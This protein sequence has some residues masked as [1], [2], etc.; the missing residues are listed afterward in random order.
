M[1]KSNIIKAFVVV[2]IITV[3]NLCVTN[4]TTASQNYEG[5]KYCQACHNV[6]SADISIKDIKNK[7]A[8]FY[9]LP[10]HKSELSKF[11]SNNSKGTAA[12]QNLD[13]GKIS[14]YIANL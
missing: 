2:S 8:H 14:T 4:S 12:E 1:F 6:T 11:I 13:L 7:A 10:N 3:C 5:V 9:A